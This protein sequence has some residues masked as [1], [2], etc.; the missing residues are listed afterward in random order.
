MIEP[1]RLVF[2]TSLIAIAFASTL[3]AG[4][5]TDPAPPATNT[6][7]TTATSS[8]TTADNSATA[9]TDAKLPNSTKG[10]GTKSGTTKSSASQEK[11]KTPPPPVKSSVMEAPGPL[12]MLVELS[13]RKLYVAIGKAPIKTFTVAVGTKAHPTPTGLFAVQHIVWNPSWHPPDAAWAKGKSPNGPGHPDNPMKV[14]KLFFQEPDY[15]VHGTDRDDSLGAAASHG[16]I[17]MSENDVASL[18]RLVMDRGGV[19]KPDDWYAKVI[20]GTQSAD[21]RLPH[22]VPFRIA[23]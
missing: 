6:A 12:N 14:V 2:A 5:Q 20:N 3:P 9:G 1:R 17:R 13:Q 10:S 19:D 16:C 7:S 4:P 8:S 11:V 18:A 22:G 23:P 15:Y 21:V